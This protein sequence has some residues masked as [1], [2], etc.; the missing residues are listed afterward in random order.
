SFGPPAYR[1]RHWM[2][3]DRPVFRSDR[4]DDDHRPGGHGSRTVAKPK[5]H[6]ILGLPAGLIDLS[7]QYRCQRYVGTKRPDNTKV[8]STELDGSS[9]AHFVSAIY[10]RAVA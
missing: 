10:V 3:D 1:A 5:I 9:R 7:R 2:A 6:W 4:C 8:S